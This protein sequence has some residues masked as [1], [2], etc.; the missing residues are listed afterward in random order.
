MKHRTKFKQTTFKFISFCLVFFILT[1]IFVIFFTSDNSSFSCKQTFVVPNW[2]LIVCGFL[3]CVF[4]IL[5]KTK[6]THENHTKD[7]IFPYLINA[8]ILLLI[9]QLFVTYHIYFYTNWDAGAVRV[10]VHDILYNQGIITNSGRFYQYSIFTNNINLTAIFILIEKYFS[11]LDFFG[12]SGLLLCNILLVNLSG[13]FT[14]LCVLKITGEKKY[15]KITWFIFAFLVGLSPW[16]SIPYSDTFSIFFPIFSFYLYISQ[17]PNKRNI[18]RWS[19]IGFLCLL[20]Y[21]IKPTSLIVLIAILIV[22]SVNLFSEFDWK[23]LRNKLLSLSTILVA[24][25]LILLLSVFLR[26]VVGI[27]VNREAK[28]TYLHYIMV[29][30]NQ[31]T[32]GIYSD[33]DME[34]SASFDTI[35]QRNAGDLVI[36]KQRLNNFGIK[37]Y[38]AFLNNKALVNFADGSFAWNREG[39]FF[40]QIPERNSKIS[41][42]LRDVYYPNGKYYLVYLTAIQLLW[43]VV[44][45]LIAC[46]CSKLKS[47][48]DQ[49]T[50]VMLALVGII[51]FVMIFE[52]RARYLFSYTP[53]FIIGA[54]LGLKKLQ[55]NLKLFIKFFKLNDIRTS[56]PHLFMIL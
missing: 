29:G 51:V 3:I 12:Y 46:N 47:P 38:L 54:G 9:F 31:N 39:N 43:F 56:L 24:I 2:S 11:K 27:E 36:I 37:G 48:D 53:F 35:E 55:A 4:L 26:N 44:L 20:G 1:I 23:L 40:Y 16:I 50:T 28:F 45:I 8:S 5:K 10:T 30:L 52:A 14:S 7:E 19:G 34:Y 33:Q 42:L 17:N 18:V 32:D 49:T 13:L 41:R 22:E 21:T 6:N 15:A 25:P